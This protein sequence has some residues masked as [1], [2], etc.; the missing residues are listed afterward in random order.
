MLRH[1][2]YLQDFLVGPKA[3]FVLYIMRASILNLIINDAESEIVFNAI[4]SFSQTLNNVL[5]YGGNG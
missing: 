2:S 5:S 3:G 4:E 1:M